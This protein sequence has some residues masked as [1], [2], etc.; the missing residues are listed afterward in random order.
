MR[1]EY[2]EKCVYRRWLD[3][4]SIY[5]VTYQAMVMLSTASEDDF[6]YE[7]F[8]TQYFQMACL[9]L[10]ERASIIRFNQMVEACSVKIEQKGMK[11]KLVKDLM[12]IQERFASFQ[13]QLCFEE[14]TS[15]E[16]GIELFGMMK[17]AMFIDRELGT[18]KELIGNMYE[19]AN[20]SSG[21]T[22]NMIAFAFTWIS[23]LL[24]VGAMV[25][26]KL[27]VSDV[28]IVEQTAEGLSWG[29]IAV[30][31]VVSLMILLAVW[32]RSWRK[33]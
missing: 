18:I 2:I 27:S 24:A 14:V 7:N 5:T 28:I 6:L 15:Q 9:C 25:F 10:A 3:Y 31:V 21:Y 22:V 26:D 16:Q 32:I 33:K 4:E 29:T 13:G 30:L 8:R 11:S 12:D 1:R 17:S 23:A 20:T 19:I